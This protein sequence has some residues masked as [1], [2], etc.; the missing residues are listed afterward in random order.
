L[1][2]YKND[3][4]ALACSLRFSRK[5][6]VDWRGTQ[7]KSNDLNPRDSCKCSNTADCTTASLSAI[8][9]DDSNGDLSKAARILE[10]RSSTGGRPLR[11]SSC[12]S[13][14]PRHISAI[15]NCTIRSW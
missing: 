2:T 7:R 5:S 6:L 13:W 10:S 4:I 12:R 11:I 15:H 8:E 14:R 3:N 9:R 1:V